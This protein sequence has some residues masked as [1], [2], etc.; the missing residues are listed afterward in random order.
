MN[1]QATEAFADDLLTVCD[2][3][4]SDVGGQGA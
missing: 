1:I 3:T 4:P 2:W